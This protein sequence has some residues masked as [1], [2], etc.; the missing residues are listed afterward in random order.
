MDNQG[1]PQ[2]K[3]SYIINLYYTCTIYT[4]IY[5]Y[6]YTYIRT[7]TQIIYIYKYQ[8]IYVDTYRGLQRCFKQWVNP[9]S[10]TM[11]C[12]PSRIPAMVE[13][14]P[15]G[16]CEHCSAYIVGHVWLPHHNARN[17]ELLIT[18]STTATGLV[19]PGKIST[20]WDFTIKQL[21]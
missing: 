11:S 5:I 19:S 9:K 15:L 20:P 1:L 21:G 18:M 12:F 6:T 7:R 3:F 10:S 4:H 17:W 16:R 8:Y 14:F 2:I 13:T